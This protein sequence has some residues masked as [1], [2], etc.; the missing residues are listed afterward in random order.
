M[1]EENPEVLE[2]FLKESNDKLQNSDAEEVSQPQ[3]AVEEDDK[4]TIDDS[5][6]KIKGDEGYEEEAEKVKEVEEEKHEKEKVKEEEK[7]HEE[8]EKIQVEE[9]KK[10]VEESA[11]NTIETKDN[12]DKQEEIK[13]AAGTTG[14]D[15][16]LAQET[17]NET[18]EEETSSK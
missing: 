9:E 1:P 18:K 12:N 14:N 3:P 15:E 11:T 10:D 5:V 8:E 2:D 16:T 6:V 4:S 7:V 13:E 17:I